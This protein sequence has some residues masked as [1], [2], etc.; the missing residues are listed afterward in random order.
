MLYYKQL[1]NLIICTIK[2]RVILKLAMIY[3]MR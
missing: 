2:D 1:G 3:L